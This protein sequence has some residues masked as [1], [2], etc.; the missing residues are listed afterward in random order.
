M[1]N[2]TSTGTSTQI[3]QS[4][5][6]EEA[7][8]DSLSELFSRDPEGFTKQ[9]RTQIIMAYRAQRARF[10]AAQAQGAKPP[11]Q[12]KAQAPSAAA[13]SQLDMEDLGL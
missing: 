8:E 5:L 12:P 3:P 9:D 13:A 10:E 7:S 4:Q 6:L 11:K 1:S 2:S